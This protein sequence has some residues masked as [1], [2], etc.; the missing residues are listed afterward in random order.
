M[1]AIP[2]TAAVDATAAEIPATPPPS[3]P[4][5]AEPA[6][7][8]AAPVKK[9]FDFQDLRSA[10]DE[11][12][13]AP[14]FDAAAPAPAAAAKKRHLHL[15]SSF[16]PTA[17]PA[18]AAA[19]KAKQRRLMETFSDMMYYRIVDTIDSKPRKITEIGSCLLPTAENR[20]RD[21]SRCY[22]AA[23]GDIR[24]EGTPMIQ[25][26]QGVRDHKTGDV[27]PEW[28]WGGQTAIANMNDVF[29]KQGW[30]IFGLFCRSKFFR[31]SE[32]VVNLMDVRGAPKAEM[33]KIVAAVRDPLRHEAFLKS[34]F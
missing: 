12:P 16:Q 26:L 14:V 28:L 23:D 9:P 17:N 27:H 31:G 8:P 3:K 20:A 1:S 33:D 24:T 2:T 32:F 10:I 19:L 7:A 13:A 4:A 6:P 18:F 22:W 5:V 25:L 21:I 30:V 29:N 11:P 15:S 34:L